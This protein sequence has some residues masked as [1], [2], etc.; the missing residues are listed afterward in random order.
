MQHIFGHAAQHH[1]AE[2]AMEISNGYGIYKDK[3]FR[4]AHMGEVTEVDMVRLFKAMDEFL[5][6]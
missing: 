6:L 4:V 3:A 5:A 2:S 1:L